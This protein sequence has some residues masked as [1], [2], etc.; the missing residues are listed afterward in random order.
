ML[1]RHIEKREKM[2]HKYLKE[3]QY[4]WTKDPRKLKIDHN[5]IM[6]IP[7]GRCFHCGRIFLNAEHAIVYCKLCE[8]GHEYL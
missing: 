4:N 7:E 3:T 6:E 5:G 2:N 1:L 8:S